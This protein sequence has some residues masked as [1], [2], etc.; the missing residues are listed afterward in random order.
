MVVQGRQA[1]PSLATI[2]NSM[3]L[4]PGGQC[5]TSSCSSRLR[6][7]RLMQLQLLRIMNSESH[8][9]AAASRQLQHGLLPHTPASSSQVRPREADGALCCFPAALK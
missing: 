3:A 8:G 2:C 4:T 7:V 6:K 1:A 9:G 5:L